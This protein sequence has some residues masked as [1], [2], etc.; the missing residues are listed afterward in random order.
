MS[1]I[2]GTYVSMDAEFICEREREIVYEHEHEHE[3][4]HETMV[5]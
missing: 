3:H 2:A 5:I 1:I 4:E